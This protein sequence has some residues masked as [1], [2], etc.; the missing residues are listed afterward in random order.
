MKDQGIL[1]GLHPF[2]KLLLLILTMLASTLVIVTLG[3][4]LAMPFLGTDVLNMRE[5][6]EAVNI[7]FLKYA[8]LLSH[9]GLFVAAS[10][11]F[12]FLV[13][14]NPMTYLQG[15]K[16]PMLSGLI[17]SVLIMLAALP[18]VNYVME[19]NQQLSL[20]ESLGMLEEWMRQ[21]EDAAEEMTERFLDVSSWQGLVFNIFL[22]AVV[23]AVGEEFIFR[24]ALQRVLRQWFGNVH[25]AVIVAAIL[26]SAMHLQFFGFLPRLVL[27]LILGYMFVFTGNIWVPVVAHFFNNAAA[28][29]MHFMVHNNNIDYQVEDIGTG[30]MAPVMSIISLLA[31]LLLFRMLYK[32]VNT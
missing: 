24:G 6:F 28:V 11:I 25:I 31:V 8:Q 32:R 12:A 3:M 1:G 17:I 22:I 14:R 15:R 5:G 19:L 10:L 9:L 21:S 16:A 30:T 18:M 13:G 29:L 7:N 2:A 23:P 27:G 4:L 26:F 20:P